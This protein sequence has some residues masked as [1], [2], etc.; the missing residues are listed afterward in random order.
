MVFNETKRTPGGSWGCSLEALQLASHCLWLSLIFD[1]GILF[2][3]SFFFSHLIILRN[4]VFIVSF[5]MVYFLKFSFLYVKCLFIWKMYCMWYLMACP[6]QDVWAVVSAKVAFL[7]SLFML[8]TY[9]VG[10]LVSTHV[11]FHVILSV[12]WRHWYYL[13]ENIKYNILKSLYDFF[14][15]LFFFW[16]LGTH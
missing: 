2:A 3:V 11:Q 13:S 9:N 4:I 5:L 12:S 8:L 10:F 16:L 6:V 14:L 7:S 15:W 1:C